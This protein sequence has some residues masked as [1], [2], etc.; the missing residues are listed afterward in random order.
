LV[1]A[2][3]DAGTAQQLDVLQAQDSFV[4]SEVAVA[5][6]H[7]DLALADLQLK[8]AAGI[9]PNDRSVR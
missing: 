7:F 2:Q 3:Y 4:A 9:F 6:A 5:Q 8:R 1:R